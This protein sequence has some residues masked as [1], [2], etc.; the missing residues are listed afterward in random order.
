LAGGDVSKEAIF[1]EG[2]APQGSAD[3][4][5]SKDTKCPTDK[6]KLMPTETVTCINP[7]CARPLAAEARFCP[8]CASPQ[9]LQAERKDEHDHGDQEDTSESYSAAQ[10]GDILC[11]KCSG[12]NPPEAEVCAY[13][14]TNLARAGSSRPT[15]AAFS[16]SSG[17]GKTGDQSLREQAAA[18][19][20]YKQPGADNVLVLRPS[21]AVWH[22]E[23]PETSSFPPRLL[24][25]DE[26]ITHLAH[27]D[28]TLTPQM[29]LQRAQ[30]ALARQNVPVA[31][32]LR[33]VRWQWG[34]RQIRPR[35]VASL[36]NHQYSS[37]KLLFGLDY[38]GEWASL[39]L[40]IACEPEPEPS[41]HGGGMKLWAQVC[42][43]LGIGALLLGL[44]AVLHFGPLAG[45]NPFAENPLLGIGLGLLLL[46]VRPI[47]LSLARKDELR[48]AEERE[49]QRELKL[50]RTFAV[51]DMRLFCSAMQ[52][53]FQSIVD[54]IVSKGGEVTRIEGGQG[55]F[56]Q[57]QGVTVAAPPPRRENAAH[58]DV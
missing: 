2:A 28:Q 22:R 26:K 36:P 19:D 15:E 6:E 8:F 7:D 43:W 25:V 47:F 31:L 34:S 18:W 40:H 12:P 35:L 50:A 1:S 27:T 4:K 32:E 39:Q 33:P 10:E 24:V 20:P 3:T 17:Q 30:D 44:L 53:V 54:D 52:E 5:G 14:Q 9:R 48:A 46:I 45:L 49:Y 58:L 21:K 11:T 41:S 37:L 42:L 23:E 51:D 55:G 16:Y 56:F 13:C 29:L 38:L 57:T